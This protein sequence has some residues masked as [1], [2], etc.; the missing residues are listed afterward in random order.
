MAMKQKEAEYR[1]ICDQII[2]VT[3]SFCF[4]AFYFA[5]VHP[6]EVLK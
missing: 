3:A 4:I 1:V 5:T 6:Y 2:R